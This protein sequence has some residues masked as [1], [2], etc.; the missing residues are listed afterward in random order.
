MSKIK[1][2]PRTESM[3]SSVAQEIPNPIILTD[4]SLHCGS[5]FLSVDDSLSKTQRMEVSSQPLFQV[6]I[7]ASSDHDAF[8][9]STSWTY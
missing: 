2:S 3:E 4:K 8:L 5:L 7:L 1:I 9:V 6:S